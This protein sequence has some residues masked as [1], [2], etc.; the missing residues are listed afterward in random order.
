MRRRLTLL[1]ILLAA[2]ITPGAPLAV[3]A[4]ACRDD[5]SVIEQS[6]DPA[7]EIIAPQSEFSASWTLENSGDCTWSRD[8]RLLFVDGERMGGAR[9]MRLQRAVEPGE[10][11]TLA[12]DLTAPAGVQSYSGSW[13][14][15]NE[16]GDTFGPVLTVAIEVGQPEGGF[17]LPQVLLFGGLGSP[18][19]EP[20]EFCLEDGALLETPTLVVDDAELAEKRHASLYLC[21]LPPGAEVSVVVNDPVGNSFS[22]S[23]VQREATIAYIDDSEYTGTATA[24]NLGWQI[25]SPAGDWQITITSAAI[26]EVVILN[27][28]PANS[29]TTRIDSAPAGPVNPFAA[30]YE[31]YYGYATGQ[32]I[33]FNGQA[34]S[35]DT[36]LQMGIYHRRMGEFY[37]ASQ[38]QVRT[39]GAGNFEVPYTTLSEPGF[40]GVYLFEELDQAHFQGE[41]VEYLIESDN[42]IRGSTCFKVE[43][44]KE[45]ELPLRLAMVSNVEGYIIVNVYDFGTGDFSL[46]SFVN[47]DC[48]SS[49]PAWW[50]GGEW[51]LYQ[52]NCLV[53]AS[54][55]FFMT[56]AGDQYDL[57]ASQI[58]PYDAL[59]DREQH[60]QLTTTP[61][62]NETE[63]DANLDG[64]IVYRKATVDM[65]LSSSG[66]LWILDSVNSTD[67]A[68]GLFGRAPTWSPDGS[69][70]AFMSDVEGTWQ[71]YVYNMEDEVLTLVSKNCESH[72]SN[73]A[74]SPN[75]KQIIYEAGTARDDMTPTG[76]WIAYANGIGNPRL[77]LAG[78]FGH[79]TWSAA[80]WI[81]FERGGGIYRATPGRNPVLE[82]YLYRPLINGSY[83]SPVW[84]Y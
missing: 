52:S 14:L 79:P 36:N 35:P 18:G 3:I 58:D 71:I 77:Y 11:I 64:L 9:S 45:P 48:G 27:V 21:S 54:E 44:D 13:R 42:D 22:R 56:N 8:Y 30:P 5:A 67:T 19:D 31:C 7:A 82:L 55:E 62:F 76:L 32:A 34:L 6:L 70:I 2:L 33:F 24:V 61:D 73:P 53:D 81:A 15:R 57:Y 10:S 39:D 80:G 78:Q 74:W 51:V 28:P 40:Y 72:C 23:Y 84:S 20:L 83:L 46:P 47:G 59:P 16:E 66:E 17:E 26:N 49:E 60:V 65:P 63:P 37:R 1:L 29:R 4:Q 43:L 12:L 75:G 50:P 69:R 38:I 25:R 68:L 41:G